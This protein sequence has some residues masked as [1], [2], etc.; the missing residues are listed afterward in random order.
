MN[1]KKR[2]LFEVSWEVCNKVGGIYTV[3]ISK[4]EE[5]KNNL[6]E[7]YI[8]IGPLFENNPEFYEDNSD[9]SKKI[10]DILIRSGVF[11]KVGRW[12]VY[13]NPRVILVKYNDTIDQEKTLYQLW[14]QYGVDS[15]TGKWDYIEPVLFSTVAAKA[16]E[17]IHFLFEDFD[18]IAH[19]HEWMTGAGLLYL[20]R[21]IP[22]IA[23]VF[24]T[25]ATM[26]GRCMAGN[27]V[28]IYSILQNI[29]SKKEANK[30]NVVAKHSMESASAMEA[31]CFTTVSEITAMEARHILHVVPDIVLT[32][33]FNVN[34]VPDYYS[35]EEYYK[36]NREK[37]LRF[38]S[39]FL[40][41]HFID[42]DTVIMSTSGRY[43]F[44][45]KGIDVI[46]EALGEL[47]KSQDE[48]RKEI[49]MFF[50]AIGGYVDMSQ[51]KS[52]DVIAAK[53]Q[54]TK[55]SMI[56]THP[57]WDS[58]NDPIVNECHNNNLQNKPKDRISII[59]VPVYLNGRDGVLNMEYY[60]VLS[61]CDLTIYPSYYEPWGYTP[62]ESV[63]YSI[64]T[65]SSDV[66]G[67]G[68]WV[69]SNKLKG[70]GV[71]IIKRF[72][73]N[74]NDSVN[75]LKD[76]IESF[77]SEDEVTINSIRRSARE[78][79][80]MAEWQIFFKNYL[81]AYDVA[82]ENRDE[83]ISGKD[84]KW[85]ARAIELF[86]I[87]SHSTRPRFRQ[88]SI[89]STIPD[90]LDKLRE[91]AYNLWWS[92]NTDAQELFSMLNPELFERLKNNPVALCEI[93]DPER[94]KD[95][96]SDKPFM[97]LYEKVIREFNKYLSHPNSFFNNTK[98]I[99]YDRP[100]AYFSMEFGFHESLPLYSGGL[101][102]LSGDHIK[103]ASDMNLPLIGVGLLY[104][105][106]YF[107]QEITRTGDQIAEYE[108]NDFFRMPLNE[109]NKNSGEKLLMSV[110]LPGRILYARVWEAKIGRVSIYFMDTDIPMNSVSD[111]EIT[112]SLYGGGVKRR[113]EQEILLGVGGVILLENELK[114]YPSVYHINEGHSAF[115][116]IARLI[117]LLK[118]NNINIETAKE[119]I[120]S[121]T[122]FTTHTPV[123]AGNES[124]DI[125]IF[126]TYLKKY[127]QN[128]GINFKDICDMGVR[129]NSETDQYEMTVLA[130]RNSYRR[131]GVSRLHGHISRKMWSDIWSGYHLDEVPII[132]ITNGVHVPTW[133]S[134]EMKELILKYTSLNLNEDLLKKEK[135]EVISKIPDD[136]LWET[137]LTLKKRLFQLIKKKVTDNWERVGESPHLLNKFLS[138]LDP[139]P[140]TIG[141]GRR[142]ATYKRALLFLQNF[143][144]IKR[145]IL[146]EDHP[147]QFIFAGKAHPEDKEGQGLIR[148]IVNISKKEEF[149]GKI[150]F[151]ENYDMKIARSMISGVDVWLNNPRR[152]FEASGTS[153]QK[154][155]IN[156]VLNASILDG[157]WDELYDGSNG[158]IIGD[159][160][161]YNN[162]DTQDIIDS[163][164]LYDIIENKIIMDYYTVNNKSLP[165]NWVRMMKNSITSIMTECN[166]HRMVR[167][168]VEKMYI[169][170]AKRYFEFIDNDFAVPREITIW[171]KSIKARF[172][173]IQIEDVIIDGIYSDNLTIND[174]ITV[175][176]E[177]NRGK[178]T[179]EEIK[180]EMLVF[181]DKMIRHSNYSDYGRVNSD[182]IKYITM[183]CFEEKNNHIKYI[184]K[185]RGDKSGKY[186]FGIRILPYNKDIEDIIDLNLVYWG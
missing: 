34:K 122:V 89:K 91:L 175:H 71:K 178:V 54:I 70:S 59:Y 126:E 133:L 35:N 140:L 107:K 20:K 121:S 32:N 103:S 150:I 106:G 23:T 184:G 60:D 45:N 84:K 50:F 125:P 43:E 13:E 15:M 42:K 163:D 144:R 137:H 86:F 165:E 136:V 120:K 76:Y 56:S 96:I 57:L 147:I 61:G 36:T 105:K 33:G 92:W 148:E 66:A 77:I 117:N 155:A 8:L 44:H 72:G 28:D 134:K 63:A 180:A 40:S 27:G 83:R 14:E 64:P 16:I 30:F 160:K 116:I 88:F 158:W 85:L 49:I 7:N 110:D 80:L 48:L 162:V 101:G 51:E 1:K 79:A 170:A 18:I 26:L 152:P 174:E 31:D 132:H 118:N 68:K 47:Y 95:V 78:I 151:I 11:S 93:T 10:Q 114:I 69:M 135:W 29:D 17:A 172:S 171:K 179:K 186:N 39:R 53:D 97:S 102:I 65:V 177:I 131:N 3:I 143:D 25:H 153:G 67:F 145:L 168:Y 9:D 24:T 161:E 173:T 169:P 58:Y 75:E 128:N 127:I 12:N 111:R 185:Y 183:E 176:L 156:G 141:F 5:V 166:T 55:Y 87:K 142:F 99:S 119:I 21:N 73:L 146:D 81:K 108:N 159:R 154:A 167:D 139:S 52:V 113:I 2:F 112:S 90:E 104:K 41:K 124:F 22:E 82:I 181:Q 100:V 98:Y 149:L 46:I 37:I 74:Y 129:H 123:A 62:L 164:S 138:N 94:L 4:L 115:L 130:L 19:F 109:I 182:D 157:W 6:G 38:A